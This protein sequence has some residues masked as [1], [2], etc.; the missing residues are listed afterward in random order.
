MS[1]LRIKS[2]NYLVYDNKI[3]KV[4]EVEAESSDAAIAVAKEFF[5]KNS[6]L[7][8]VRIPE[9]INLVRKGKLRKQEISIIPFF[10]KKKEARPLVANMLP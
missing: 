5:N 8:A 3:G 2:G 10:K 6:K 9:E 7:T 4:V 1:Y